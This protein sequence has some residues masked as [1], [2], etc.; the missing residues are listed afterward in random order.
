MN[1]LK[2][3]PQPRKK[4]LLL[5]LCC[6]ALLLSAPLSLSTALADSTLG[7]SQ[8]KPVVT[9]ENQWVWRNGE[10][11]LIPKMNTNPID[12][13]AL[14]SANQIKVQWD[15]TSG[16]SQAMLKEAPKSSEK[17]ANFDPYLSKVPTSNNGYIVTPRFKPH[18]SLDDNSRP[19]KFTDGKLPPKISVEEQEK[20]QAQAQ[21]KSLYQIALERDLSAV[22]LRTWSREL[23]SK[24]DRLKVLYKE[25]K[26]KQ[27]P[28]DFKEYLVE[29]EDLKEQL[30]IYRLQIVAQQNK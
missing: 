4:R 18:K 8:S 15:A 12:R 14:S 3:H 22:E 1:A 25:V 10:L 20:N 23:K 26:K 30:Q 6:S 9:R 2:S 28:F 19:L 24:S 27:D 7:D 16:R 11:V 17:E 5:P 29:S 13:E 21:K